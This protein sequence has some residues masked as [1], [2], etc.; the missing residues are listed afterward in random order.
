MPNLNVEDTLSSYSR[1]ML[2]LTSKN[3]KPV[4]RTYSD[5][6]DGALSKRVPNAEGKGKRK[7][8]L[9][10]LLIFTLLVILVSCYA[11]FNDSDNRAIAWPH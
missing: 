6:L 11:R 9:E 2:A 3:K 7:V 8:P 4:L 10:I 1:C 5:G